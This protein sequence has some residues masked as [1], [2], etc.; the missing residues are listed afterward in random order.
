MFLILFIS[1]LLLLQVE[2]S[3][4][5]ERWGEKKPFGL[6][7]GIMWKLKP[8][9]K[10]CQSKDPLY[11]ADSRQT[12]VWENK[13]T[14]RGWKKWIRKRKLGYKGKHK[15]RRGGLKKDEE[16]R[17]EWKEKEK[18]LTDLLFICHPNLLHWKTRSTELCW[19]REKE[20]KIKGNLKSQTTVCTPLHVKMKKRKSLFLNGESNCSIITFLAIHIHLYFQILQEYQSVKTFLRIFQSSLCL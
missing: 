18:H 16:D 15:R 13:A 12:G 14:R 8:Q 9:A 2:V 17:R 19:Q 3:E 11:C 20:G 10:S 4:K 7:C 5:S 1:L 6:A